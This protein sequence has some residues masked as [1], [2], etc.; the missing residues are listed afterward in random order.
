VAYD[1]GGP[2]LT[3]VTSYFYR[4]FDRY[5]DGTF[6]NSGYIGSLLDGAGILG[7]DGNL[8]GY[9]I[10]NV[11]SPVH[12]RIWTQQFT[13]EV[14]LLSSPYVPGGTP[15]TWIAGIYYSDQKLDSRDYET[16]PGLN[17]TLVNVYG[18][19]F[20][21]SAAFLQA[22]G[23]PSVPVFPDDAVYLQNKLF[24]ERQAAVFGEA[25]YHFSAK[26][27][28]T[29]GLRYT[30]ARDSLTRLGEFYFSTGSPPAIKVVD[31]GNPI[32]PKFGLTYYVNSHIITY[33]TATKGFRLGGPNRPLPSFCPQTPTSYAADSL[34]S[35]ETGVKSRLLN[36]TLSV[37]G[38]VFYIDWSKI[39]VDINL[40]CTFD[41][42]T[43]AG[44][45]KSYGSEMQ[46]QFKPL[47]SLLLTVAAGYTH[48]TLTQDVPALGITAGQDVPGVPRW[49]LDFSSRYSM[50]IGARL[51]G[52][53]AAD[54]NYV[55]SS[56][57]TVGITDPDYNRPS[58]AV[59]GLSGGV[60][61]G[62]WQVAVFARNVFNDQ[63]IIQRPNL[64]TVNRGYTLTPRTIGLSVDRL[65]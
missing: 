52:Y 6:Y 34:W 9:V 31:H 24:G 61:Y 21:T 47:P 15:L 23:G 17:Q 13:Q 44:N 16:A 49:S 18:T 39:Q 53:V 40:P 22:L 14:R 51:M 35:Y 20:L 56:H 30:D 4:Y 64:Q 62:D 59:M 10:G 19:G 36:D 48:A 41:Y 28:A 11:A 45:A 32:T 54:W 63:K 26:F 58:Y 5:V 3:S 46:V 12:Y 2:T 42:Y 38:D 65:F 7:L 50:P 27:G 60:N 8:D 1:L 29:V 33:L 57:G 37:T 43:N 25:T 55:G